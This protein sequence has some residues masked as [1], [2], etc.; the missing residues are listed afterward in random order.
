M[1]SR[2]RWCPRCWHCRRWPSFRPGP[3]PG[4]L[5]DLLPDVFLLLAVPALAWLATDARPALGIAMALAASQAYTLATS[6]PVR[7]QVITDSAVVTTNSGGHQA[8]VPFYPGVSEFW[9]WDKTDLQKLALAAVLIA[10]MAWM[11]R[12]TRPRP[13]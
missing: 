1:T 9:A 12:R 3:A 10:A 6:F 8:I 11:L 7:A 5:Q 4:V 13:R 2:R